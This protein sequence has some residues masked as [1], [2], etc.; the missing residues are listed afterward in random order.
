MGFAVVLVNGTGPCTTVWELRT[1][2]DTTLT[3]ANSFVLVPGTVLVLLS[4]AIPILDQ[5][6]CRSVATV[7]HVFKKHK[8]YMLTLLYWQMISFCF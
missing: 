2:C 4:T 3:E 5:D 6:N 8:W 7:L 1:I